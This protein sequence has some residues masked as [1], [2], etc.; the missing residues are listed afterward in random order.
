MQN[1]AM[2]VNTALL[3]SDSGS[4]WRTC[5]LKFSNVFSSCRSCFNSVFCLFLIVSADLSSACTFL[6]VAT[7]C[8][9]SLRSVYTFAKRFCNCSLLSSSHAACR[10]TQSSQTQHWHSG[11][12]LTATQETYSIK[13]PTA[14]QWQRTTHM[15]G[16]DNTT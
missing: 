9:K 4:K 11:Q 8:R 10:T 12:I 2:L 3:V 6:S 1:T 16:H 5:V 15:P 13:G 14:T 7:S